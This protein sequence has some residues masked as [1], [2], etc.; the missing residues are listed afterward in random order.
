MLQMCNRITVVVALEQH[1]DDVKAHLLETL[2]T[3]ETTALAK[4]LGLTVSSAAGD[5]PDATNA[6][7][8]IDDV[9]DKMFS[10]CKTQI[11]QVWSSLVKI[12]TFRVC[13]FPLYDTPV[14]VL[15]LM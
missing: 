11:R 3:Q 15:L 12:L 5:V 13:A 8:N 1:T 7:T 9:I 4:K 14:C 6:S 10:A 2:A